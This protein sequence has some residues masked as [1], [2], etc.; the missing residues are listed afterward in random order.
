MESARVLFE[1]VGIEEASMAMIAAEAGV[2]TPTVFN[3]FGSR[4]ELLLALIFQGHQEA[5]D[6]YR[7]HI[8]RI[9]DSLS[10][11][12]CELLSDLTKRSLEIFSKPVWR[13]AES[14]A[15]R[16]PQSEFVKRYGEI[17]AALTRT[18]SEMLSAHSCRT[19]Q[20]ASLDADALA[21]II[22]SHWFSHY[23][24]CLRDETMSIEAHLTR[25]LQEIRHMLDLIF[26]DA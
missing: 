2:S 17:D 1:R 15:I 3:Y 25:L 21:S 16:Y 9:S 19:R 12:L 23:L 8:Q 26:E 10:N 6:H 22:Y 18:I 13:Y 5:I 20:G 14:T 4:D 7:T 24:A 11:D